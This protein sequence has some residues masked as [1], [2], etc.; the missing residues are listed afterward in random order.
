MRIAFLSD[1]HGNA[2]ALEA[3]LADVREKGVDRIA[4]LGDLAYRGPEPARAIDLIRELAENGA[5]VIQGNADLWAV[6]GVEAGEVPD[7]LL[8]VMREE[9]E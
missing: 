8:D 6:R 9:R 7:R 2:E 3:V 1:I 4:V 5:E